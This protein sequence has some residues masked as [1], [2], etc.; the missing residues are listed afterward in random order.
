MYIANSVHIYWTFINKSSVTQNVG[1][2]N[3]G[4]FV[5][6]TRWPERKLNKK[7]ERDGMNIELVTEQ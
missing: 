1:S 7:R 6:I 5:E 2:A 3:G 4:V